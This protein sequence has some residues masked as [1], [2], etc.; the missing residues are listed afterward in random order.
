MSRRYLPPCTL[1]L[2]IVACGG[3]AG[4]P[5]E[6]GARERVSA[7]D[8]RDDE[9]STNRDDS[10]G[11]PDDTEARETGSSEVSP[12][13]STG[14]SSERPVDDTNQGSDAEP[15]AGVPVDA[16][17]TTEPEDPVEPNEPTEPGDPGAPQCLSAGVPGCDD[18]NPCCHGTMCI[19]TDGV[20]TVCAAQCLAPSD[21][22]S[23]CCLPMSDVAAACVPANYCAPPAPPPPPTLP[24]AP[25][26]IYEVDLLTRVEQDVYNGYIGGVE[27]YILTR[28]CYEYVYYQDALLS[29]DGPFSSN[30]FVIGRGVRSWECEVADVLV[31]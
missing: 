3:G 11:A 22:V 17:D 13:N 10:R 18:A 30:S 8:D 5:D 23:G 31:P 20:T 7:G 19:T 2:L 28:F 21:C 16:G 27:V 14:D 6:N 24:S 12:D 15:D 1:A 9:R 4:A 29:W 25:F 26:D